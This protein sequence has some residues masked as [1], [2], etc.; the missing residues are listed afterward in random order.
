MEK[1]IKYS[2]YSK[3]HPFERNNYQ[4]EICKLCKINI[5][6]NFSSNKCKSCYEKEKYQESKNINTES[7]NFEINNNLVKK[8][9]IKKR[10]YHEI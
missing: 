1:Y 7:N 9:N 8:Q 2:Q 10:S 5:V 6:Y 3:I 4:K